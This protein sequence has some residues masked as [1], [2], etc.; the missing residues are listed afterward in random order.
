MKNHKGKKHWVCERCLTFTS[1]N[2]QCPTC[3]YTHLSEMT[4]CSYTGKS[5]QN[6]SGK[7][8]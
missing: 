1:N 4:I 7:T 5:K 8:G 3:G 6:T 2:K